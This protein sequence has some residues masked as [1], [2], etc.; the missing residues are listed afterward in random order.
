MR[1]FL[2]F[3]FGTEP[4]KLRRGLEL[5]LAVTVPS[6]FVRMGLERISF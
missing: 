5:A 4:L 3:E 1:L 2:D 6:S